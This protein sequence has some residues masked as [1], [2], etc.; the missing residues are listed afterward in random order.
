M[1]T[2]VRTGLNSAFVGLIS[3]DPHFIIK[4]D[5]TNAGNSAADSVDF[6][7]ILVDNN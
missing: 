5:T 3:P 4:V 1:Y 7:Y 2:G 6:D